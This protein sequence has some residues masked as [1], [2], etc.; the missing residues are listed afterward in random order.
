MLPRI[1][2][3]ALDCD[4]VALSEVGA[5]AILIALLRCRNAV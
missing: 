1:A 2:E 3:H 4:G 5:S